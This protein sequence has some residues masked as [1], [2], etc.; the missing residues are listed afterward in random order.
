MTKM[1]KKHLTFWQFENFGILCGISAICV[2]K[3]KLQRQFVV[4]EGWNCVGTQWSI[5]ELIWEQK[6]ILRRNFVNRFRR[7]I[8]RKETGNFWKFP[9]E[10]E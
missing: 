2:E 6:F 8:E 10:I 9:I 4:A 1:L 7:K 3:R 5:K